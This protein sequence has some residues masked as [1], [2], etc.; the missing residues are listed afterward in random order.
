MKADRGNEN[1]KEMVPGM[2]CL[3]EA[4]KS[5]AKTTYI[6]RKV[7]VNVS[8]RLF[9]VSFFGKIIMKKRIFYIKLINR[10]IFR[11]GNAENG[12]NSGEFDN[13]V[14]SIIKVYARLLREALRNN[15]A[16]VTIK[17]SL[18]I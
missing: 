14:E 11:T 4:I 3:F 15:M 16:F 2:R 12:T 6:I 13:R 7:G 8:G 9:H 18:T 17:F 5:F 10:P 1:S